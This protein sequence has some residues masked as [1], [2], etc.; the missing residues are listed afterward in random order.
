V[1]V[2]FGYRGGFGCLLGPPGRSP[3][4]GEDGFA[5]PRRRSRPSSSWRSV[6]IPG[7]SEGE[8]PRCAGFSGGA[9]GGAVGGAGGAA[10]LGGPGARFIEGAD[11]GGRSREVYRG[12]SSMRKDHRSSPGA[13]RSRHGLGVSTC[14]GY[15][16]RSA[17]GGGRSD[18]IADATHPATR[19]R[20][21]RPGC[22]RRDGRTALS[23]TRRVTRRATGRP[24]H[25]LQADGPRRSTNDR[26]ALA[27]PPYLA[28]TSIRPIARDTLPALYTGVQSM[29]RPSNSMN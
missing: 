13:W 23:S 9:A 1:Y 22:A 7:R 11:S 3:F 15:Q 29:I 14:R 8:P 19:R 16:V 26:T 5:G 10:P 24:S 21:A 17:A 28:F 27:K 25:I 4:V 18:R 6:P 12:W 20:G 2:S